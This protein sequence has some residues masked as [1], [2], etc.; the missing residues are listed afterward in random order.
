MI[1]FVKNTLFDNRSSLPVIPSVFD[2]QHFEPHIE[3]HEN[4]SH[5]FI[6]GSMRNSAEKMTKI[7]TRYS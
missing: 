2:I 4:K 7:R 6:T 3:L 1:R 5:L